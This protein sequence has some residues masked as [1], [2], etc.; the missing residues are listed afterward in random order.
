MILGLED[1]DSGDSVED[2]ALCAGEAD[3]AVVVTLK[4]SFEVVEDVLF[5]EHEIGALRLFFFF[6]LFRAVL[7]E[8]DNRVGRSGDN[9][10][11]VATDCECPDLHD[12]NESTA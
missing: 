9:R 6:L 11:L 12:H 3:V 1:T 10:G 7:P 8:C 5:L 2:L 4:G